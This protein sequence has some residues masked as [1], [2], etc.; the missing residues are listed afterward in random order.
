VFSPALALIIVSATLCE[1]ASRAKAQTLRSVAETMVNAQLINW[2]QAVDIKIRPVVFVLP[3]ITPKKG[4]NVSRI[5]F[6]R[7][8]FYETRKKYRSISSL[9]PSAAWPKRMRL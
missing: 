9:P 8:F 2:F 5:F 6:G 1:K 3:P 4:G 7:D